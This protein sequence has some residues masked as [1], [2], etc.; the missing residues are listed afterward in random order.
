MTDYVNRQRLDWFE[1]FFGY[2]LP[3][4][5]SIY[6]SPVNGPHNYAIGNSILL[7]IGA[8]NDGHPTSNI[9]LRETLIHEICHL[10]V[11][12][13]CDRWWPEL[14]HP[15]ERIYPHVREMMLRQAYPHPGQMT[16]EWLTRL[17]VHMYM[18]YVEDPMPEIWVASDIEKG[19]IWMT[20]SVDCLDEFTANRSQYPTFEDFMPRIAAHL[21]CVAD[22][23]GSI[24]HEFEHRKPYIVDIRPG[25]NTDISKCDT[26]EIAFSEP[27]S[28]NSYGFHGKEGYRRLHTTNVQWSE[29]GTTIKIS[30][31]NSCLEKDTVYNLYLMPYAFR[32]QRGFVLDEK[33]A[34]LFFN[35]AGD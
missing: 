13:T 3:E 21:E 23:I 11:N 18:K 10:Y 16:K 12:P 9:S 7:G 33:C 30:I 31:D 24:R 25:V 14:Q 26:I 15:A 6:I 27:M 19:F 8:G 4:P 28:V 22:N 29:D 17:C 2:A 34:S 35:T 1:D 5:C 20:H 32:S